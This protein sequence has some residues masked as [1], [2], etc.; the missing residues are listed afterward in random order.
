M[1][2]GSHEGFIYLHEDQ[3]ELI[4][5]IELALMD[6]RGEGL[7][8][9]DALLDL[10]LVTGERSVFCWKSQNQ[11]GYVESLIEKQASVARGPGFG[12][13]GW[14]TLSH[15]PETWSHIPRILEFGA[16]WYR[17]LGKGLSG[18]KLVYLSGELQHTGLFEVPLG[19]PI[20]DILEQK[21]GGLPPDIGLK[22]LQIGGSAGGF[23]PSGLLDIC[24]DFEELGEAG[25]SLNSG[26]MEVIP[27]YGLHVGPHP[28]AGPPL[29][30]RGLRPDLGL[31]R[32]AQP[33]QASFG[34]SGGRTRHPFPFG[35]IAKAGGGAADQHRQGQRTLG[36][37]A[38][39]HRPYLF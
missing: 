38:H 3:H 25:V 8:G 39:P 12:L 15:D 9:E 21:G 29:P 7:V 35:F 22:A 5:I 30:G 34:R 24:L 37:P 4:S 19:T 10:H 17:G 18:S 31:R 6:A 16:D 26:G 20:E 23:L 14:P 32:P 2:V 33:A 36:G 27:G 13:F 11:L 1:A 28:G